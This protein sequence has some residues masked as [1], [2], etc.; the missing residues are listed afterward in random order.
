MVIR[1]L[2]L[3]GLLLA[4]PLAAQTARP[5]P[6]A[7]ADPGLPPGV[8]PL[9]P[10]MARRIGELLDSAEKYRGLEVKRPVP[11]GIVQE[12]DLKGK[13]LEALR[14]D[15]P[16]EELKAVDAALKAFGLIPE[17]LDL[18][19]YYPELLTSQIAGYYDPERRYLS[20]VHR[21]GSLLGEGFQEQ[22]GEEAARMEE[23]VL[24]HELT[25]AIQDQ[26]FDL[27]RFTE[28]S[29]LSDETAA[30]LAL[31]EGDASLT[32][33][34]AY[35]GARIEDMPGA[36][37]FLGQALE[38][39]DELL[40]MSPDL[41]GSKE[42]AAAPAW[43]RDT[44]IFSYLQGYAFCLSVRQ[45]GG[46]KLLDYAFRQ[47]PPRSSE[48]I[49]HP[50]KWHG[51]R[52]DPVVLS[53]PDLSA[54]LPGA[55]KLAEGEL[56]EL[57]IKIL[58]RESADAA[59]TAAGWGGDRFAVY[60][61]KGRRVLAW[62]TEWDTEAD[63]RELRTAAR[64]LGRGWKVEAVAP[65]R[66][67]IFR[68]TSGK[69]L[70]GLRSRLAAVEARRPENR[71]LDLAALGI[72]EGEKEQAAQS[73]LQE[74]IAEP[75]VQE[76][77]AQERPAGTVSEDGRSY[78]NPGIGLSLT[79]PDAYRDW[80]LDAKPPLSMSALMISAP[81][82]DAR[83]I[84]AYQKMPT[85]VSLEA[86][87]PMLDLGL[88]MSIGGYEELGSRPVEQGGIAGLESRFR[89]TGDVEMQGVIRVYGRGPEMFLATATAP[90]SQW[91]RYEKAVLAILDRLTFAP[92]SGADLK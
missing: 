87:K 70:A 8:S 89:T 3:S 55:R 49:L 41:P 43:L 32:M 14:E 53:W 62:I 59:R 51:R 4:A 23:M 31:V 52:D 17:S 15:M 2:L 80:T 77:L 36:D 34:N 25:H 79:L 47:D 65:R 26:H 58:L 76:I 48:Q 28:G 64:R 39:P 66:V 85:E 57:G 29:P 35:L 68:R 44:M 13:V 84:L 67:L 33:F 6:A 1:V 10:E 16:V 88:K 75:E 5:E 27:K 19:S 30:R 20:L 46:Q 24:V 78:A 45:K 11:S 74:L 12:K 21:G 54:A 37:Q 18:A 92:P 73:T 86:M 91:Q 72:Q 40:E 60:E 82:G 71:S 90:A 61:V 9:S 69:E 38:D 42:M 22:H 63:A 83:I 7:P 56:G 81:E 50:E